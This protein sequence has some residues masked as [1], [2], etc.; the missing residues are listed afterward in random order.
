MANPL[1]NMKLLP[2][3]DKINV[4]D[5]RPAIRQ[6]IDK[7][8]DTVIYITD[9]NSDEENEPT[10][11]SLVKPIEESLDQLS[12]AWGVVGHLNGVVNSDELR[13][14][15]DELLPEVSE[16]YT[17]LGQNEDLYHAYLRLKNS[18]SFS[19]LSGAQQKAIEEE[20]KDFELCGIS[21]PEDEK[22]LFGEI[23]AKLSELS[24]K[25]SNNVLDATNS[26]I[27]HITDEKELSGLPESAKALARQEAENRNLDGYVLTLQ[28]PSYIPVMQYA[29]H[30]ALREEMYRA[31]V[32]RA[33]ELGPTAGKY[34][35]TDIIEEELALADKQA[36]LLGYPSAAHLS[37]AKKMAKSPE[38]VMNFLYSLVDHSK[39]QGKREIQEIRDYAKKLGVIYELEPWDISYFSE[40]LKQER[41]SITDEQ[42]RP[43]FPLTKVVNG[44]FSLVYRI[45]G[46]EVRPHFGVAVWHPDVVYH[47]IYRNGELIGGF[48]MDLYARKNKRGGAWMNDCA[49]RRYRA[50]GTLQ[51]PIAYIV[52]NFM[53]PIGDKPAL[54]NHD[55]VET[56]FHEFGHALHHMLTTVDI[57]QVSGINRVPWDA[58]ELPSQFMENFTWQ[59]EVLNMI[60]GHVDTHE[61][62]PQNLLDKLI[63]SKNY[64]SAMAMLRQL[65]FSIYDFRSYLEYKIGKPAQELIEE[66]RKDVCVIPVADFNRFQNSFTHIFAGGYSAGYYSYK[67][68]EV[69]SADAFSRF[70][71]EG[72]LNPKVG[73]DFVRTILSNGGSKDFMDLFI[74][75]RGRKPSVEPLLRHSGITNSKS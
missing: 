33:S 19:L 7:C 66:V 21:L 13:Q 61:T 24:S 8:R 65:E 28:Y 48:Y 16:F 74:S 26:Y 62:L 27:K 38:E 6:L 63:A 22:V 1:L 31:Y 53:P 45:F 11:D 4:S 12:R 17:W 37:L 9:I 43:Y 70:E 72:I 69:L 64:H 58:V 68:A 39:E 23:E 41:Y 46:V 3:F 57:G 60:S 51:L 42:I 32:T 29:D 55:E 52:A 35:N 40:K 5:I 30:R 59:P 36:E 75:F 56:L 47:D 18:D 2:D 50:D 71:E 54:L 20:L 25:F 73:N 67:W 14:A 49:D 34:D 44:L 10:W 15:H